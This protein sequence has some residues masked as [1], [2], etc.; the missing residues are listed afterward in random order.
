PTGPGGRCEESPTMSRDAEDD[1]FPL[2]PEHPA[3]PRSR[4][5]D[6]GVEPPSEPST[7]R[8]APRTKPGSKKPASD[9]TPRTAADRDRDRSR[10]PVPMGPGWIEWFLFGRV[11]SGQLAQFCRQFSAY[12]DA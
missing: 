9:R 11:S 7:F 3:P 12:L 10:D 8:P 4:P 2:L 6:P 1:V 5:R